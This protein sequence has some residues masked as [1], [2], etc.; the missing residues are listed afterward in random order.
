VLVRQIFRNRT[1]GVLE[2]EYT[3]TLPGRA[4]LSG[5]AVWDDTVRIPGVILERKRAQELYE[6]IR[7]QAIDPGLLQLGERGVDEARRTAVFAARVVPIPAF[8]NKRVEMEYQERLAVEDLESYFAIPLRPDLY[9]PQTAG[10]LW[11]TVEVKS[12]HAIRDAQIMSKAYPV[13]I[14]ERTAQGFKASFE[15]RNVALS[16]DFAL[17]YTLDAARSGLAVAAYRSGNQPGY[18]EASALWSLPVG[19]AP[20]AP[21]TVIALFDASLSMQWEKL[22]RAYQALEALLWSLH[23]ADRFNVLVY[24]TEVT[25][26]APAPLAA[27]P[28]EVEKALAFVKAQR[29][30]GFTNLQAALE[31]GL[32]QP[33]A[34][35]DPYLVLLGDGGSTKGIVHTGKLADWYAAAWQKKA[36]RD[37]PRTFVFLSGDDA[38]TSLGRM[39]ARQEGVFEWVRSTEPP[40][41][42]LKAFLGKIGRQPLP[43]LQL[44]AEP[45]SNFDLIYPLDGA[46]FAGSAAAWV[47]QYRQPGPAVFRVRE[48]SKQ[49]TLPA[50]DVTHEYLPRAWAK[51]RVD[52][53][54]EKIDREGEDASSIDEIIRLSKKYTF[55]TPYTSFLAAPRALLRPRL[56]RPGDPVLRVKTDASIRSVVAMFPFGLVKSLRYLP[57]E[58]TWQTRFLAPADMA[59]GTYPVRLILRDN[60]GRVY[61]EK[62]TFVILSKPPDLRVRLAKNMYRRGETLEIRADASETTRTLVARLYGAAPVALRWNDAQK[63]S[64]GRLRIPEH[65]APGRYRLVVTAEDMAHNIATREVPIEVAP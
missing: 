61:Q 3:F 22:E 52:A 18:F 6:D 9:K 12:N 4:M 43:N 27:S 20:A 44:S 17:K 62:K 26:F 1:R 30:R 23:P 11:I 33:A 14:R 53:L 25:P 15:G 46:V 47:G 55:I 41:F 35:L 60:R 54:L 40:D 21:R 5:F 57:R 58:D 38:N 24:N 2:G 48:L 7:L 29:L 64:T 50:N 59:D 31:A 37:R 42:K 34:G 10:R 13:A 32:S 8:G 19:G 28:E 36:G 45:G 65:L 56:I 49:V 51:A 39:L 16:E 63:S